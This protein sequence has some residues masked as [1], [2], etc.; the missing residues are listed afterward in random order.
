MATVFLSLGSN[1]G[2][3]KELLNNA[4]KALG[5]HIGTLL[6]CSLF[7]ETEPWGFS[8][9]HSFLNAVAVFDTLFDPEE[10]LRLTQLIEYDLGRKKKSSAGIYSDRTIDIDILFYEQQVVHTNKLII[11]HPLLHER[12]FVLQPL[13]EI[14]PDF[15]HPVLKKSIKE[16]WNY[17]PE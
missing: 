15:I 4:I 10:V 14:A 11:P 2:C 3:R 8:S 7:Y 9:K 17:I 1:L 12:S 13:A 5:E 6:R 16:L